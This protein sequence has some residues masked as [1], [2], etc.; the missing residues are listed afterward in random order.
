MLAAGSADGAVWMWEAKKGVCMQVLTGMATSSTAGRFAPDGRTLLS[1][2]EGVITVWSPK[3]GAS[4]VSYSGTLV[5]ASVAI[6]LAYHPNKSIAA[7]GFAN[8]VVL[9]V[10]CEN[11][12]LLATIPLAPPLTGQAAAGANEDEEMQEPAS[13]SVEQV[14]FV[15]G[16]PIM[17]AADFRGI[18][19][20]FDSNSWKV[21][22]TQSHAAGI[23]SARVLA[24]GV[25][26]ATGCL[27]GSIH[28]WDVRSGEPL[29]THHPVGLGGGAE[30][31]ATDNA[32]YAILELPHLRL[33]VASF[34]DGKVRILSR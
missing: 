12:Q 27:D 7:V 25:T 31:D 15:P 4:L 6:S 21:R 24:D 26:A 19:H 17:L 22:S 13:C 1:A 28:L 9:V 8:G 30:E 18:L 2:G 14:V 33:L 20:L 34:D 11:Y 5:P 10:H 29:A 23:T 3:T 32:V 16:H